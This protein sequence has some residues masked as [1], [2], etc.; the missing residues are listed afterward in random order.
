MFGASHTGL[1]GTSS[2][3]FDGKQGGLITSIFIF[4]L[5]FCGTASTIISGAVAERT[6][7]AGYFL[8]TITM[9][10]IIYP[11]N[12]HWIWGGNFDPSNA[13]W[14]EAKGFIDF[15]GATVVHSTG[16]WLALA[17]IIIIG[18]RVGRFDDIN[19]SIRGHNI[20]LASVGVFLLWFGWLGFNGGSAYVFNEGT[21]LIILNTIISGAVGSAVALIVTYIYHKRWSV[22]WTLNGALG[23]LVAVTGS[24][25][26]IST[27]NAAIIGG[28]AA[29]VIIAVDRLLVRFRIDYAIGAVPFH[30]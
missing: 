9:S 2:F 6:R 11:L 8:I 29:L 17:A 14:L 28:I 23:G 18:P 21:P 16:G 25:N 4:Q 15:A 3:L 30:A 1:F 5:M 22:I 26:N 20:P 7:F 10:A 12:G 13:G 19:N 24:A 27:G